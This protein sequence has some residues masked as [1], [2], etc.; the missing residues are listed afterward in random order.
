MVVDGS[1]ALIGPLPLIQPKVI[2]WSAAALL[3][4]GNGGLG[5]NARA[6]YDAK[7]MLIHIGTR[8]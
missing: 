1:S 3:R 7:R 8:E 2:L 4:T 6:M 5:Q